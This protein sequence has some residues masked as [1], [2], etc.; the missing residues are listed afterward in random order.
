MLEMIIVVKFFVNRSLVFPALLEVSIS[1]HALLTLSS[2][3]LH[4]CLWKAELDLHISNYLCI[5][6]SLRAL[7]CLAIATVSSVSQMFY[8]FFSCFGM[9]YSSIFIIIVLVSFQISISCVNNE[10]Y[11][12]KNDDKRVCL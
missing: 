2:S 8:L 12:T 1:V 3:S 4:A 6:I 11:D 9:C 5:I 10:D 7:R